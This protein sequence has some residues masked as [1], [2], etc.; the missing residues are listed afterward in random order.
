MDIHRF[1]FRH[2]GYHLVQHALLFTLFSL[3]ELID[4]FQKAGMSF[5]AHTTLVSALKTPNC[6]LSFLK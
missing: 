2:F 4:T 6:A 3:C 1:W 5:E